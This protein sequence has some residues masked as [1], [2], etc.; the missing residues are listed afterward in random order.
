MDACA[1]QKTG[2][3]MGLDGIAMEA[4]MY[5]GIRLHVHLCVLFNIFVKHAY[6]PIQFMK[7]VIIP[8]AKCKTGDLSDVNNYRAIAISTSISKLFENVLSVHINV[9]IIMMHINLVLPLVVQGCL[10]H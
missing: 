6:V 9:M 8:L 2:K 3:A 7:C 1:T 10:R 4:L 5:G